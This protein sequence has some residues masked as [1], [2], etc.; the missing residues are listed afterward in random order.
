[1]LEGQSLAAACLIAFRMKMKCPGWA[2]LSSIETCFRT[3][4]SPRVIA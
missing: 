2:T 3:L 1:M 4:S